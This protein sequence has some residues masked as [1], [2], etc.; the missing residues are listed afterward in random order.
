MESTPKIVN[1]LLE[2][3]EAQEMEDWLTEIQMS[4]FK[5]EESSTDEKILHWARYKALRD[6]LREAGRLEKQNLYNA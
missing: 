4:Y 6:F 5:N 2:L 3:C 1:E